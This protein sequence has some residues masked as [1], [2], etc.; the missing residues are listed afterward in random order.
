MTMKYVIAVLLTM[1]S[2][3]LNGQVVKEMSLAEYKSAVVDTAGDAWAP[4]WVSG[5]GTKAVKFP[6]GHK[7]KQMDGGQYQHVLLKTNGDVYLQNNTNT[8][9]QLLSLDTFGVAFKAIYV[10]CYFQAIIAVRDDSTIWAIRYNHYNWFPGGTTKILTK[11]AKIPGQPAGVKFVKTRKGGRQGSGALVSL[12][13]TGT[14]YTMN[15]VTSGTPIWSLKSLPSAAQNIHA[16]YNG[17]YIAILSGKPYGWGQRKYLTGTIGAINTF[18]ALEDD[19]GLG[20]H[21]IIDMA[22]NDNTIHYITEDHKLWGLGDNAQGEVGTGTE[23][24]NRKE[25]YNGSWYIWNW[26]DATSGSYQSQEFVTLPTNIRPDK[27]FKRVWASDYYAFYCFAQEF[28]TDSIYFWGRNKG[29]VGFTNKG[30]SNEATYPNCMDVLTPTKVSVFTSVTPS[31]SNYILGTINAGINQAIGVNSTTLSGSATAGHTNNWSYSI[32]EYE[33]TKISGPAPYTIV[34]PNSATTQVTGLSNGTYAFRLLVTDNNTATL[35]DTVTVTVSATTP[36]IVAS[37]SFT[38]SGTASLNSTVTSS[39]GIRFIKWTVL[40]R[41]SQPTYKVFV[42]G[43]STF[44]ATG[45]TSVDSGCIRTAKRTWKQY[46]LIDTL[47]ERAIGGR[48]TRHGLPVNATSVNTAT[49]TNYD[50]TRSVTAATRRG[51]HIYMSGYPSNNYG[52]PVTV[53]DHMVQF[54]ETMDSATLAGTEMWIGTTQP[55]TDGSAPAVRFRQASDSQRVNFPTRYIEHYRPLVVPN[56]TSLRPELSFGDNIH[57]NNRGHA[58]LANNWIATNPFQNLAKGPAVF[59]NDAVE[60][61]TVSGLTPGLWKFMASVQDTNGYMA[62]QVVEITVPTPPANIPPVADAG[63]DQEIIG[64]SAILIGI[65]SDD[66]DGEIVNYTWTK[67]SGP[68]DDTIQEPSSISTNVTFKNIG[69]YVYRLIVFDDQGASSSDDVTITVLSFG[70]VDRYILIRR[71]N[72]KTFEPKT[73][74]P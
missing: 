37:G 5:T 9:L 24:V 2:T 56:G 65:D 28:T 29:A 26:L 45:A 7:F 25:I 23:L 55:R 67:V 71:R 19:W 70:D 11:W 27:L 43:S 61:T 66:P 1:F 3:W 48:D 40:N 62:Y 72:R 21:T 6:G 33:W 36:K 31:P 39:D 53:H 32:A 50:S 38:G 13:S 17:F 73:S 41:P 34:N 68:L 14:V 63:D 64:T 35:A 42:G 22:L 8:S 10:E 74:A 20:A 46:G 4:Y 60:N 12:T 58:I 69:T 52:D 51:A 59:A 16:S 47:Y 30:A 44:N 18:D 15:D 49:V 57:T 54:K